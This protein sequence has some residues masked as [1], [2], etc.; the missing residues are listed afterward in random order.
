L[1]YRRH[2]GVVWLATRSVALVSQE[3]SLA[4]QSGLVVVALTKEETTV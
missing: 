4:V 1:E 2:G 3:T